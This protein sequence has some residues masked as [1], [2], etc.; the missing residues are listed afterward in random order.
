[1]THSLKIEEPYLEAKL[2]GHKLFEIRFNDRGFQKGDTV[3]YTEYSSSTFEY[4]KHYFEITYVVV[5]C[6]W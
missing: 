4:T 3:E 6:R 5:F 2:D 1:M